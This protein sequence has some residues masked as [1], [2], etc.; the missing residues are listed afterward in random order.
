MANFLVAENE[1]TLFAVEESFVKEV[2][3]STKSQKI[4][5]CKK[6]VGGFFIRKE[7]LIP[8]YFSETSGFIEKNETYII[9]NFNQHLLALPIK[10]VKEITSDEPSILEEE[11][12]IDF[13]RKGV[14][15]KGL[16]QIP[17]LEVERLYKSLR[18][19]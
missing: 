9:L 8:V 15:Y 6:E 10:D 4:P 2:V 18:L 17:L 1:K 16:F 14:Y 7:F 12:L 13:C 11:S 3:T 19:F 5:F